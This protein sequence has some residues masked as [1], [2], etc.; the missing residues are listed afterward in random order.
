MKNSR[1]HQENLKAVD[2]VV[3]IISSAFQVETCI[4]ELI[5]SVWLFTR[6]C[7][8][9]DKRATDEWKAYFSRVGML[10]YLWIPGMA[11]T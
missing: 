2:L 3:E 7:D 5:S 10:L 6:K 9:A 8:L 4:D 11:K 1:A